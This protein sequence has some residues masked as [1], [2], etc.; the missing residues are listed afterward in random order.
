[1]VSS[2]AACI[3]RARRHAQLGNPNSQCERQQLS[4]SALL[5]KTAPSHPGELFH[6]DSP[7]AND[8]P[9]EEAL[10]KQFLQCQA[11]GSRYN[12]AAIGIKPSSL[13]QSRSQD[14]LL[15]HNPSTCH[16]FPKNSGPAPLLN[17]KAAQA[18]ANPRTLKWPWKLQAWVC[19]SSAPR[20]SYIASQPANFLV[21][22][23]QDH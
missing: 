5:D 11:V 3:P 21:E 16:G 4:F 18:E 23:L 9:H 15:G 17:P 19:S 20:S 6:V 2:A 7:K 8:A 1:M 14:L 10:K 22:A 13:Q 12:E